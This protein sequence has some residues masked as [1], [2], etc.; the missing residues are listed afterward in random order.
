MNKEKTQKIIFSLRLCD[1]NTSEDYVD[2]VKFL[3]IHIDKALSWGVHVDYITSKLS[4][5][6][7]LIKQLTECISP[8]YIK[9]A[10]FAYFQSVF[11]YCLVF[12]GNCSRIGEILILQK[13]VVRIMSRAPLL[14]HCK[15]LYIKLQIQTVINI[16]I[17]D[18]VVYILKNPQLIKHKPHE[19]NTRK[20]YDASIELFRLSKTLNSHIVVSVKIYNKLITLINNQCI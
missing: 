19:Y 13:K 1:I 14:E 9:T 8:N 2:S 11:R 15:P 7:F 17:F 10:Y 6:I 12:Y 3:G 16:Y 20:K 18:L 4:R 5:V